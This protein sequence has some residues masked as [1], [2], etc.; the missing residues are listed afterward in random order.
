[1][2]RGVTTVSLHCFDS[3]NFALAHISP[4]ARGSCAA[5]VNKCKGQRLVKKRIY[6][7]KL[8]QCVE[9]KFG[10]FLCL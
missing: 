10:I 9:T 7:W 1:M 5:V 4:L 8:Q 3:A 2:S 6:M